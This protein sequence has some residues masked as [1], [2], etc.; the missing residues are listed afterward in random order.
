MF[1]VV[2]LMIFLCIL[3]S[4]LHGQEGQDPTALFDAARAGDV[5][6][7]R[8]L[9]DAGIPVD[10]KSDYD[11]TAL[12][13]ACAKGHAEV[14]R[15]LLAEGADPNSKDRFYSAGP[16]AWAAMKQHTDVV[17]LLVDSGA[18]DTGTALRLAV[19]AEDVERTKMLLDKFNYSKGVLQGIKKSTSGSSN[20]AIK[21][22]FANV[23]D[24]EKKEAATKVEKWE[25]TSDYL[26]RYAG[27]YVKEPASEDERESWEKKVASLDFQDL[28]TA[29]VT[30]QLQELF[31][32]G[33]AGEA[34]LKPVKQDEFEFAGGKF[35]F[36]SEGDLVVGLNVESESSTS[37][38][39]RVRVAKLSLRSSK[40]ALA[41]D[42]ATSS[43]N[44]MQFRGN[45]A[46]GVAE[47][48]KPPIRWNVPDNTNVLWKTPVEG[49]AHSCPVI[50]DDLLFLTTAISSEDQ[51]GLRTGVYG[52]VDSVEDKSV[53]EF[54]VHCYNKLTGELLWQKTSCKSPPQV[55]RH[56]KSTHANPTPA[57]DGKYVVAFFGSEGLYCYTVDG[58]LVWEKDLGLL[59]SGW[60]FDASFQWGFAASPIIYE[61]VVIVQ[62][63]IQKD[64]F[65]AAY[66]IDSGEEVWR[67]ERDEIPTW[68]TPTIVEAGGRTQLVTNG[69]NFARSYDPGTGE[70]LWRI[71]KN[72]EIVVPTPFFAR[73]LIFV[74][75][76]YRPVKPVYAIR[77]ECEWRYFA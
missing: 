72:S 14:I 39:V 59:D 50:V 31:F 68:S 11:A 35:V 41:D 46:R 4:S 18:K 19:Q 28:E 1:R 57:T 77:A 5:E 64:S 74:C 6:E 67:V 47:G 69:T 62:C 54:Q 58:E 66:A 33:S 73:D 76:G 7:V 56:L 37:R 44:W 30:V 60:F 52:D 34:T 32:S 65:I 16:M 8:R 20:A 38:F 55:K 36:A 75:S 51:A 53:H 40:D 9:L 2:K 17:M 24:P 43:A 71:G 27:T 3:C 22:L 63:D 10:A 21:E 70:E 45:G 61:G 23:A 42:L 12:M 29:V 25:P 13:F 48:Q 15:L 26:D 49:L